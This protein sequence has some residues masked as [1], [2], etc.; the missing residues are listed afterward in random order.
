MTLIEPVVRGNLLELNYPGMEALAIKLPEGEYFE[1]MEHGKKMVKWPPPLFIPTI[2]L[3][4]ILF[5]FCGTGQVH[6][7]QFDT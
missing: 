1:A 6:T 3:V 7:L 5:F 4:Q 2:S